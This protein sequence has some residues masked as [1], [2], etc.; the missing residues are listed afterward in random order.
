[1]NSENNNPNPSCSFCGKSRNEAVKLIAGPGVYICSLC[2][3]SFLGLIDQTAEDDNQSF[4]KCHCRV[5]IKRRLDE[6]VIEQENAKKII[7]VAVYNHYKRNHYNLLKGE[8]KIQKSNI[9]LIGSTG[10]GKT[11]IAQTLAGLLNVPFVIADAT[12][13]TEAGYVGEDV[14]NIIYNLLQNADYDVDQAQHGI[15]YIDEIDKIARRANY[16]GMRDIAGEGVQQALLKIMEGTIVNVP[17]KGGRKLLHQDFVKIDTSNILFI[18]GGAFT[19]IDRIIQRRLGAQNIGYK[20]AI[21]SDDKMNGSVLEMPEP[22]DVLKYGFIPEFL[23]RL[24]IVVPFNDLSQKAL[25]RILEEP[26]NSLIKQYRKLFEMEN[27]AL[28][29]TKEALLEIVNKAYT[30]K[31]GARGLRSIMESCM[32]DIMYEI[33][34]LQNIRE[35]IVTEDVILNKDKPIVYF[36]ANQKQAG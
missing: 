30:Y 23:G 4:C 19:G 13:L 17:Q 8:V 36:Y 11:L 22:E 24:P 31:T 7:S 3:Q 9:L 1:M 10:T 15:V 12:T 18:C 26:K 28:T 32:L 21:I 33:P 20:A 6:Y 34:S 16:S 27:V 29:F 14:E 35:C 25:L 5:K 2:I